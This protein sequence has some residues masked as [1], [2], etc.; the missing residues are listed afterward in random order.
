MLWHTS[1]HHFTSEQLDVT[2]LSTVLWSVGSVLLFVFVG[3]VLFCV[4]CF[5]GFLVW[6]A[7]CLNSVN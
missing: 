4:F 5:C 3:F 2:L 6:F 7:F 1:C